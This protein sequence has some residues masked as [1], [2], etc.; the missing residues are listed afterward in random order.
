MRSMPVASGRVS[1]YTDKNVNKNN[2]HRSNIIGT[3]VVI[4]S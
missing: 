4:N 1:K 3:T 2:N